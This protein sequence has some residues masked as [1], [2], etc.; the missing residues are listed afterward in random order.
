[1][2]DSRLIRHRVSTACTVEAGTP[3]W[4][5]ICTGPSRLR[6]RS[7][8]IRFTVGGGVFAGL[9]RGRELR[10]AMPATPSAA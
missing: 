7:R 10:S 8:T 1:M 5:A 4:P 6:Q 9:V 3:V 2:L